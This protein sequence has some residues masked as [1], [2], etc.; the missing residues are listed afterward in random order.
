MHR[1][2]IHGDWLMF[3]FH[4]LVCLFVFWKSYKLVANFDEN[5][6]DS[7]SALNFRKC[8]SKDPSPL[9]YEI[10]ANLLHIASLLRP[11]MSVVCLEKFSVAQFG[12]CC[13]CLCAFV[14]VCEEDMFSK[15]NV[16]ILMYR[17]HCESVIFVSTTLSITFSHRMKVMLSARSKTR[18]SVTLNTC[19]MWSKC[20]R[21]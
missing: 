11:R 18:V 13:L 5:N 17:I 6:W 14:C 21:C 9:E 2:C 3:F 20:K 1:N 12:V 8:T 16:Y 19:T 15:M 7:Q 4:S 10:Q